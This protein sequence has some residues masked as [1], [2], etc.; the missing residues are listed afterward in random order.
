VSSGEFVQS[1]AAWSSALNAVVF[2]QRP[3]TNSFGIWVLPM[4]GSRKAELVQESRFPLSFPTMSPDGKYL[5]Y[6]S[7]ES[8]GSE[9][10]VQAFPSGENKTRVSIEGGVEPVWIGNG[11][12][13]LFR[14]GPADQTFYSA[15]LRSTSPLRFDRPKVILEGKLGEYD[16]TT[17]SR[18]WDATADGRRLLLTKNVPSTDKPVTSI[19]VVLN[20]TEELMKRVK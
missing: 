12:E 8:G 18:S 1:P 13:L 20:W 7:S 15:A 6:V 5:A 2:T 17:P 4:Q 11:K 14:S 3:N 16:A 10:Y 9:V 19:H